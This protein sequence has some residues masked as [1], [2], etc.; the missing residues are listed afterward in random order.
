MDTERGGKERKKEIFG[1]I[2]VSTIWNATADSL[3][4][5][6]NKKIKKKEPKVK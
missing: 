2:H 5:S 4:L 1:R 3:F 6:S